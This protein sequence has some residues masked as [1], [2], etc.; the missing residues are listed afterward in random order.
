MIRFAKIKKY[1]K[2]MLTRSILILHFHYLI[3]NVDK[4]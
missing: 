4:E 3:Y 1:L 2:N